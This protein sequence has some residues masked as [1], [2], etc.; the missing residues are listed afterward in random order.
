M[1]MIMEERIFL[2]SCGSITS[3]HCISHSLTHT[4]IKI[5][6]QGVN[7]IKLK[8]QNYERF[9]FHTFRLYI[10][11]FVKLQDMLHIRPNSSNLVQLF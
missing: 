5:I 10:D 3:K 2:R 11:Q 7:W 4:L 6:L 1:G 9:I 8:L